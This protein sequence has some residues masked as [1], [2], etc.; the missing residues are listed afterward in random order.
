M[1]TRARGTDLEVGH[2]KYTFA[3][4]PP[5]HD[6]RDEAPHARRDGLAQHDG[7]RRQAVLRGPAVPRLRPV[8][9]RGRDDVQRD[10]GR[11][12]QPVPRPD[13]AARRQLPRHQDLR[14]L[15]QPEQHDGHD[16]PAPPRAGRAA[17]QYDGQIFFHALHMGKN[18]EVVPD[19]TYPQDIR[20]CTTCHDPTAAGGDSWYTYPSIAACGSCH[21]DVNF[22][23]GAN[24]VAGPAADGSC[25][26]CHQPAGQ[27]GVGRGHQERPRRSAPVVAAQGLQR[28]DPL[29]RERRPRQEDHRH[30]PAHRT[31]TARSSTRASTR[32]RRT[33]RIS[34][35]LGGPTT[36]YTNVGMLAAGQPFSEAAQTATYNATTGISD[37]YTFTNAIPAAAKGTYVVSIDTAPRDHAEPGAEGRA[38][39]TINEGAPNVPFYFAVTGTTVT[40]RRTVVALAKCNVCHAGPRQSSSRTAAS[41]SRPSTASSATTR[42]ARRRPPPGDGSANP[43]ESIDFA[44]HDPP[45]PHGRRAD[46]GLHG[47]RVRRRDR[48]TSTRSRTPATAATASPAT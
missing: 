12:L 27:R 2:Y 34:I 16:R 11:A 28:H 7:H 26:T 6:G 47:L 43:A 18:A 21:S 13:R 17:S 10:D 14:P 33:A 19:I 44:A 5:G 45:H 41:A 32:S 37:V 4:R 9:E 46:A 15:P 35:K 1:T 23:T 39:P 24:H 3:S 29:G 20:F 42:T 8:H 48:R 36:D 22:A 38:P 31:A 40:P 30:L 25:A